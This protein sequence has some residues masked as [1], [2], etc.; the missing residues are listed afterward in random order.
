MGAALPD[1]AR[2]FLADVGGTP[3]AACQ[4]NSHT[5][6][7]YSLHGSDWMQVG[8]SIAADPTQQPLGGIADVGGQPAIAYTDAAGDVEVDAYASGHWTA[9]GSPIPRHAG[10]P[11]RA[12]FSDFAQGPSLL[13]DG[14]TPIVAFRE[15]KPGSP[16]AQFLVY[17]DQLQGS[18]LTP[19]NGDQPLNPVAADSA[20]LD[21]LTMAG[22]TP[23][24]G[25][26]DASPNGASTDVLALSG[27]SFQRVGGPLNASDGPLSALALGAYHGAPLAVSSETSTSDF[28]LTARTLANG[29]WPKLGS[30]LGV[31]PLPGSEGDP[32]AGSAIAVDA[33]TDTPYV[34]FL[35]QPPGNATTNTEN[36]F[37]EGFIA[38]ATSPT[39]PAK[40]RSVPPKSTSHVTTVLPA[41]S[42]ELAGGPSL[43]RHGR[44]L[45][46]DTGLSATCPTAT[47]RP[48]CAG[49][50]SLSVRVQGKTYHVKVKFKVRSGRTTAVVVT[51]SP[52]TARQLRK[53]RR[54]GVLHATITAGVKGPNHRTATL[55][56]SLS[57]RLG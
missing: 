28:A 54:K 2:P 55:A 6:L 34:I 18:T 47:G 44:S 33:H 21:G 7:V 31:P 15:F 56:Q 52:A 22:S 5:I 39:A 3:Y 27:T 20:Y 42:L 51:L 16:S 45:R 36:V 35:Q 13:S 29:A 24:L 49:V 38:G 9:L 53:R 48:A 50:L 40:P 46:L 19:L 32:Y 10:N 41:A 57:A 4:G 17:A 8:P 43:R 26:D 11:G 30:P 12:G 25:L 1:C 37:V 14:A 23:Y